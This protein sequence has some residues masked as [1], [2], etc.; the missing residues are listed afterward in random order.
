MTQTVAVPVGVVVAVAAAS[1]AARVAA[2]GSVGT[3]DVCTGAGVG[4]GCVGTAVAGGGVWAA[5]SAASTHVSRNCRH[6]LTPVTPQSAPVK[7][8]IWLPVAVAETV[9]CCQASWGEP[10]APQTTSA[11]FHWPLPLG[12]MP[13]RMFICSA[14]SEAAGED[15]L[16]PRPRP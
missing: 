2:A 4:G 15:S 10:A 14:V 1:V 12:S 6:W 11:S 13:A 3:P 9:N 7:T 5:S 8:V 16:L